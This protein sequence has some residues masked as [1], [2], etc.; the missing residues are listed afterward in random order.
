MTPNPKF[1]YVYLV[2]ALAFVGLLIYSLM[3][4]KREY[5]EI[6]DGIIALWLFY[7]ALPGIQ[8]QERPG[9]DVVC[10]CFY[11]KRLC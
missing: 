3:R 11:M 8:N 10:N 6:Y 1:F 7:R 4:G 9:I 5:I 2:L